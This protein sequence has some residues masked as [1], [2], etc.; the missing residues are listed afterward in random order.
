MSLN[1]LGQSRIDVIDTLNARKK[2]DV[3][4]QVGISH[5]PLW[6]LILQS[7]FK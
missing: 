3:Y 1:P 7:I 2:L 5:I 6:Y 4:E